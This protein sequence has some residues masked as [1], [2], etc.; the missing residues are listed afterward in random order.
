ME[1]AAIFASSERKHIYHA[2]MSRT[3]VFCPKPLIM[4]IIIAARIQQRSE[5]SF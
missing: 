5:M 3:G 4:Y 2:A 1:Q